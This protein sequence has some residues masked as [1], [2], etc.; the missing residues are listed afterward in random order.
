MT[1][2]SMTGSESFVGSAGLRPRSFPRAATGGVTVA[3]L[4]PLTWAA[5]S[6]CTPQWNNA[7]G[8]PG[9]DQAAGAMVVFDDGS[10]P[11]LF[12]GGGFTSAGGIAASRIAK[13]NGTAW[14]P[15]GAGVSGAVTALAVYDDGRGPALYVGGS[16]ASAGGRPAANIAR[17]DGAAWEPLGTGVSH[18]VRALAVFDDGSGAGPRLYVG[19]EF[20]HAG[21]AEI[22]SLATWDGFTWSHV[23][24]TL[25]GAVLALSVCSTAADATDALYVAGAFETA[26]ALTV[27]RIARWDGI[28]WSSLGT[29]MTTPV[30]ALTSFD[31]GSGAVLIASGPFLA[32]GGVPANSIAQWNGTGWSALGS[33]LNQ[34]AFS[35][36][37]FDDGFGDGTVLYAGG[38]FTMAGG[39]P[40]LRIARWNGARWSAVGSGTGGSVETLGVIDEGTGGLSL[41]A[42]GF[43]TTADGM[44][45]G[46]IARWQGCP[47]R[48]ACC[49]NG[50]A[51]QVFAL[52]CDAAGG[53]F[54]GQGV[55]SESVACAM[56]PEPCPGDLNGD[57][58]VTFGDLLLLL[59]LWGPCR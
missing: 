24:D 54:Q 11:A 20:T 26:G 29:G 34:P 52:E 6:S 39:A 22:P 3:L 50:A 44:P 8:A 2:R 4:A 43:F 35:L 21:G 38:L 13:W 17:W 51:I 10:G 33:G 16:F 5:T 27:N 57:G 59:G 12:T 37:P 55:P 14:S 15:L 28:E 46:H 1:A 25:S 45:A 32:A 41:Y 23:G 7:V 47:I 31:D 18:Q 36:I 53:V 48:G 49:I 30:R 19:G 42:G 56:S 9:L 58:E 40:A